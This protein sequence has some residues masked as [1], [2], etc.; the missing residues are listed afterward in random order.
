MSLAKQIKAQQKENLNL[1]IAWFGSQVMTAH[2]LGVSKQV[3]SNWVAR[4]KISATCAIKAEE[5]TN[6]DIKKAELRPDVLEWES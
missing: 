4:G 2:K 5:K 1:L 6:G 3:V